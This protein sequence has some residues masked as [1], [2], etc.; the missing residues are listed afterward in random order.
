MWSSGEMLRWAADPRATVTILYRLYREN[1][2]EIRR[3]LA[4]N[5]RMPPEL[6]EELAKNADYRGI[7]VNNPAIPDAIVEQLAH[8]PS[9][10]IRERVVTH[11]KVTASILSRL[12][13][14][15]EWKVRKAV[16]AN[17]ATPL[18][19]LRMLAS[20]DIEGVRDAVAANPT[21]GG[22]I[23]EVAMVRRPPPPV[24]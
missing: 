24:L 5:R 23:E 17:P 13:G 9:P 2:E 4:A 11:P 12:A 8:D 19:S 14:D 18:L 22:R 3:V 10:W 20:D 7:L 16:A 1:D 6:L 15:E 21:A